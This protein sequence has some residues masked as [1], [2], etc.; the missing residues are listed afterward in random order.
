MNEGMR[1]LA[2]P[3]LLAVPEHPQWLFVVMLLILVVAG[4]AI[5]RA[6]K[7]PRPRCD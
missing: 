4:V 5:W 1:Q 6:S 2:A 3:R 7:F